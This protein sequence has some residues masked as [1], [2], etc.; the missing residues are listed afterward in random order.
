LLLNN[1]DLEAEDPTS[2][3]AKEV[4]SAVLPVLSFGSR[5]NLLGSI[6]DTTSVSRDMAMTTRYGPAS[7]FLTITP[8]DVSSPSS[9]RLCYKSVDNTSFPATASEE[10]FNNLCKNVPLTDTGDSGNISVPLDYSA[11]LKAA[12][13]N[14]AAVAL[15]F[16]ALIENILTVLIG[17][18]PTFQGSND[19]KQVRSWY[20]KDT[21][22][23]IFG[24]VTAF[25][26]MVETQQ[27]G[28][29]HFHVIIWGG[30]CPKLL[31]KTSDVGNS[32]Q[33]VCD[34]VQRALDTMYSVSI[35]RHA[36]VADYMTRNMKK[37]FI[38][39]IYLPKPPKVKQAILVPPSPKA[40]RKA[41]QRFFY[42]NVLQTGIHQHTFT[43]K[44][45]PSG[46]IYCKGGKPSGTS[47]ETQPVQLVELEEEQD[48]EE[49]KWEVKQTIDSLSNVQNRDS[50]IEPIPP[51]DNRII[52]GS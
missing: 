7:T 48:D 35:P 22:K 23:G 16:Q 36:H 52:F 30:I 17:C 34:E 51:L 45:A 4:L 11:R 1:D 10:F 21:K 27:R 47:E 3:Q 26:G 38:G 13:G 39:K 41:W 6:G 43:C 12:S 8:D 32:F 19:S 2:S 28:A 25:F 29:M 9:L 31:E 50:H 42:D 33:Q 5:N 44:K 49:V 14:P 15:E 40:N 24:Y 46:S 37:S 20:F 18:K